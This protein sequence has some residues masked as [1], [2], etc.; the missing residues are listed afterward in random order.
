MSSV[1]IYPTF[2]LSGKSNQRIFSFFHDGGAYYVLNENFFPGGIS[3][4]DELLKYLI[5]L[6][7]IDQ[8][9]DIGTIIS[10]R[11]SKRTIIELNDEEFDKLIVILGRFCK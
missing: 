6:Q 3:E 2:G 11:Y 1:A 8:E 5:E 10:G 4:R 7:V 9:I